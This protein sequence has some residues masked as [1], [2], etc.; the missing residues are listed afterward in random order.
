[1]AFVNDGKTTMTS[2]VLLAKYDIKIGKKLTADDLCYFNSVTN[3][4]ENIDMHNGFE[5]L[6]S[7][8]AMIGSWFGRI[9]GGITQADI[10]DEVSKMIDKYTTVYIAKHQPVDIN[11]LE[12]KKQKEKREIIKEMLKES[13]KIEIKNNIWL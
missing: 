6:N 11:K 9:G 12:S 8:D 13:L 1:M 5:N 7:R 2:N 3:K 10:K 4:I